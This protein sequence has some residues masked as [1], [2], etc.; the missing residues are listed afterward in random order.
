MDWVLLIVPGTIWGASFLFIAEGLEGMG[1][2]GV[3]FTRVLVGFLT[4]SLFSGSR[5]AIDRSY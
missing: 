1:P 4:L 5:R 2:N 3:T